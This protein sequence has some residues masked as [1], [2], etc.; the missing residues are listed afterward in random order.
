MEIKKNKTVKLLPT[1]FHTDICLPKKYYYL[2]RS[3][4]FLF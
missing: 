4:L 2:F 1:F 3:V